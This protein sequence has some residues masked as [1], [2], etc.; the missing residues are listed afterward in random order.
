MTDLFT[1]KDTMNGLTRV[2]YDLSDERISRAEFNMR[3]KQGDY[4]GARRQDIQAAVD[5]RFGI[6]AAN[7]K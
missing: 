2:V 3:A 5:H 1:R 7:V 4:A 6:M